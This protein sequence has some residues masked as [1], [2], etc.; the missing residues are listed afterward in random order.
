M[1]AWQISKFKSPLTLI[2]KNIPII[3]SPNDLLIKICASSINPLDIQMKEGYGQNIIQVMRK[4]NGILTGIKQPDLPLTLGRD[5]S[6]V[7]CD[8]GLNVKSYKFGDEVWGTLGVQ[9]TLGTQSEFTT[10][11]YKSVSLKPNNIEHFE[12]ASLPYIAMTTFSSIVNTNFP[13]SLKLFCNYESDN[14]FFNKTHDNSQYYDHT[15]NVNDDLTEEKAN[16]KSSP[17]YTYTEIMDSGDGNKDCL[18]DILIKNIQNKNI[19][20]RAGSGGISTFVVQLMKAYNAKN[21]V[22]LCN[23]HSFDLMEELGAYHTIDYK[24]S[25]VIQ[26]SRILGP[27]DLVYDAIGN[28]F[29]S[30]T[31]SNL[32][33]RHSIKSYMNLLRPYNKSKYITV[34]SPLLSNADKYGVFPLG[35]GKS[36]L[37]YNY[38]SIRALMKGNLFYY[39]YYMPNAHFM[40]RLTQ[41]VE[42]GKIKPVIDRVFR[43]DDLPRAYEYFGDKGLSKKGKIVIDNTKASPPD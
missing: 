33:D 26:Q 16:K 10:A 24:A 12:A 31:S 2:Q 14:K 7:I 35:L 21:I 38:E 43:F 19:L 28:K 39:G 18:D 40:R 6:G 13:L 3:T 4:L 1:K 17:D 9:R 11:S 8:T 27:Y 29:S 41:L 36:F 20:I 30:S 42:S 23:P 25:D 34:S 15:K 37:D 32:D 5:F 22:V